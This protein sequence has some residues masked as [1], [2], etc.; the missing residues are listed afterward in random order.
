MSSERP[1]SAIDFFICSTF[2]D[3]S[4]Y[5]QA[6][7]KKITS[8]AGVI[9]AQEFFGARDQKPLDTCLEEVGKSDVFIMF[10]GPRLGSVDSVSGKSFVECEYLKAKDLGL[11]RFAYIMDDDHPFPTKFV[12]R[13]KDAEQLDAFKRDVRA[14]LTVDTFTTPDDLAGKVYQDLLRE[15]PKRNFKLGT[16]PEGDK[17]PDTKSLIQNFIALPRLFYGRNVRLTVK[18]GEYAR[19][20]Q[21]ECQAFSFTYGAALKRRFNSLDKDIDKLLPSEMKYVFAEEEDARALMRSPQGVEA[22]LVAKAIQGKYAM[23]I[24]IYGKRDEFGVSFLVL[25]PKVIVGYE[26]TSHLICGFQLVEFL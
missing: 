20:D 9:N 21:R 26:T 16:E 10:L 8:H 18:F 4:P 22:S 11:P 7:I 12:S 1:L 15:L 6:V 24:P 5:R 25:E 14:D 19:A 23:R 2:V 3:L 17:E 13:G